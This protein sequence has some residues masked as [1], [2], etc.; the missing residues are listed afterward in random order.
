MIAL[1]EES[2]I[3]RT[4]ALLGEPKVKCELTD[5]QI[6]I[7]IEDALAE[8]SPYMG[9]KFIHE[10]TG[11]KIDMRG[12]DVS[13]ILKVYRRPYSTYSEADVDIF[14]ADRY[15]Q[16]GAV[17]LQDI[18]AAKA[19]VQQWEEAKASDWT[20]KDGI[21]YLYN[22]S[23]SVSVEYI[24]DVSLTGVTST[25]WK[26]WIKS[27]V[28][29]LCKE[30][31]GRIRGKYSPASSPADNDGNTILE[32]GLQEQKDLKQQLI[33]NGEGVFTIKS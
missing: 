28:L 11:P 16:Y 7:F 31:L 26:N 23:S 17:K 9:E 27:Y 21:L 2:L 33:D 19:S 22:Y 4:R 25:K 6:T 13:A 1:T 24:K 8:A 20:F 10:G 5:E 14:R 12:M 3:K 15:A 30:A 29:A 18:Y 32:E